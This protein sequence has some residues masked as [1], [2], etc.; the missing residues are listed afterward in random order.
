[1]PFMGEGIARLTSIVLAIGNSS[2]GVVLVDEIE[3]GFHHSVL[4]KVWRVIGEAARRFNTQVFATTHS[5]ECIVAAHRAFVEGGTYDFGLHRLERID[6]IIQDVSYPQE[7]LEA[8]IEMSLEV[9]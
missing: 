1:M 5:M 9:R 7:V 6:K 3:N 8:A 2:N 4:H